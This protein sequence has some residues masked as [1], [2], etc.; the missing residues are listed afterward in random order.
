MLRQFSF[1]K[2]VE[3]EASVGALA[4]TAC[5]SISALFFAGGLGPTELLSFSLRGKKLSQKINNKKNN[6]KKWLGKMEGRE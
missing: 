5:T 6:S 1:A 2:L 4:G 3:L